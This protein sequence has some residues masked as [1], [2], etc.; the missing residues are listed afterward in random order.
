MSLAVHIDK[1]RHRILV[2]GGPVREQ[3]RAHIRLRREH[4]RVRTRK[5]RGELLQRRNATSRAREE[6][7]LDPRIVLIRWP[8]DVDL[9]Q[10]LPQAGLDL[11][12]KG[13]V[14]RCEQDRRPRVRLACSALLTHEFGD[15]RYYLRVVPQL[16]ALGVAQIDELVATTQMHGDSIARRR[17]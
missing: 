12:G 17:R 9:R 5:A 14:V 2:G 11:L 7:R 16:D 6:W 4:Q 15:G 8:H 3:E 13:V 1:R 10:L